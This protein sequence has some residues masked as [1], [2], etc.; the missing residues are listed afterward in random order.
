[1]PQS[2]VCLVHVRN[3]RETSE[4][5]IEWTMEKGVTDE[6]REVI[7]MIVNVDLCRLSPIVS[8][9]IRKKLILKKLINQ[10]DSTKI[11]TRK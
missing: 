7:E 6:V 11:H 3:G 5:Y 9:I 2:G 8:W 4:A 1:M 10:E